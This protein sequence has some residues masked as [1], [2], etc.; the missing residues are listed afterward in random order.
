MLLAG[1]WLVFLLLPKPA[2]EPAASPAPP[3]PPSSLVRAGLR[4]YT[5]WE[6]LPEI[7][8]VWADKA[9]WK[10]GRTRFAYWHPVMKTYSY[11][12]EAVRVKGG[13]H[14][15][16]IAEPQEPD[17]SLGE[18]LGDDCPIRFYR[19]PGLNKIGATGPQTSPP[20][21]QMLDGLKEKPDT[22]RIDIPAPPVKN[23]ETPAPKP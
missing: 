13:F 2:D 10:D 19:S 18:S 5:D 14:F 1:G 8:A 16:E 6:G 20:A 15:K 4:D 9:E 22:I 21:M 3:P 23:P 11:Y 12:F 7:F 17:Y